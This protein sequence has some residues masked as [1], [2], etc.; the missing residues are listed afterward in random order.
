LL[1]GIV[2]K[3]NVGKSTFFSAAT[4]KSVP[5]AD[6]PFTTISPNLGVGY[7]RTRCVCK[8]MQVSDTPRNSTCI[9]GVRLIPVKLVDVAGLVAGAST[10]RGMGNQ[11]LDEVRQADA[12][13]H[14]I[15]AS[16]GTDEEGRRTELGTHNPITDIKM[17]ETELDLWILGIITKDWE[18]SARLAEQT[19]TN[20]VGHLAERLSGLGIGEAAIES[21]LL[22]LRI[23]ADKPS[24][25]STGDLSNLA[26]TLR[27]HTKPSLI[28]ANKADLPGSE[29]R[30][31]KVEETGRIVVPCA[32]EAELLLRKAAEQGLIEYTPGS[33]AFR[34]IDSE[35]MS[36]PQFRALELVRGKVLDAYGSTGVQQAI[37]QA[38]FGLLRAIVVYPVED[39]TRLAD[40]D[41]RV[42]PDAYVMNGGSTALDLARKIHSDL[43][44]GFLYA[45]DARTG[46]RLSGDYPLKDR[47]I[48]KIVSSS[49]RG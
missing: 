13:I 34:I 33:E 29:D 1:V 27:E 48:L 22:R 4:L 2:G 8:E 43:A 26:R 18:R 6:Y 47:D 14:V 42:L 9:D 41:G 35:R 28:A 39:E 46:M 15:D 5:V 11:F 25:W 10:G 40:K 21:A 19:G 3:P 17:V 37:D 7:L 23:R 44:Q 24:G 20:I 32:A 12:L 45:I 16:G 30:I 36:A 49:R 38:Y 31:K